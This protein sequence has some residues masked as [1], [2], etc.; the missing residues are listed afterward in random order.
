MAISLFTRS[1]II[2]SQATLAVCAQHPVG[3]LEAS[4]LPS[5]QDGA[6]PS[7]TC[8]AQPQAR[9]NR[10]LCLQMTMPLLPSCLFGNP[11]TRDE[12]SAAAEAVTGQREGLLACLLALVAQCNFCQCPSSIM[13]IMCPTLYWSR[14]SCDTCSPC[15]AEFLA[16]RRGFSASI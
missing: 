15:T 13:T 3:I 16:H 1:L 7:L 9:A 14:W 6:L 11:P 12:S 2:A 4:G 5:C 8:C 10:R